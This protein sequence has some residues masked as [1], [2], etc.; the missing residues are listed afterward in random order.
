MAAAVE[1]ETVLTAEAAA[2]SMVEAAAFRWRRHQ[3]WWRR[4]RDNND[5]N[6]P[7]R[8]LRCGPGIASLLMTATGSTTTIATRTVTT[9]N[10]P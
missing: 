3:Q 5:G 4:K 6:D 8:R 10:N 1:T 2:A 9:D 7:R